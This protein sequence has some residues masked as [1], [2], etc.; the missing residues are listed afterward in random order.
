M[1]FE[2]KNNR[3]YDNWSKFY[4][5]IFDEYLKAYQFNDEASCRKHLSKLKPY[6]KELWDSYKSKEVQVNYKHPLTQEAYILRYGPLYIASFNIILKAIE[7]LQSINV[8]KNPIL[9][10]FSAGPGVETLGFF[11]WYVKEKIPV[12]GNS[13]DFTNLPNPG[14]FSLN[15]LDREEWEH[16]RQIIKKSLRLY[17]NHQLLPLK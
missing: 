10:F 1:Y 17:L 12:K 4:D 3:D 9:S 2:A 13:W 8:K 16:S 11:W 15:L 14:S 6:G 7:S 5:Y